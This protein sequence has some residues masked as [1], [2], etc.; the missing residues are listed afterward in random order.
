VQPRNHEQRLRQGNSQNPLPESPRG[1][2]LTMTM[3]ESELLNIAK[4]PIKDVPPSQL[5]KA[6]N[7]IKNEAED[8]DPEKAVAK[9]NSGL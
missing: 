4:I 1:G 9:F 2:E 6:I 8:S 5:E 7:R 3:I